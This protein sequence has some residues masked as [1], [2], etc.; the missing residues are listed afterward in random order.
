MN[1]SAWRIPNKVLS[2]VVSLMLAGF[3]G[4]SGLLT[5]YNGFFPALGGPNG[6]LY[7]LTLRLSQPW[8]PDIATVPAVFVAVDEASLSTPELAALPRALFQTAEPTFCPSGAV[9][10][11]SKAA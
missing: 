11:C 8:R 10:S 5:D 7:D 4:L 2:G 1:P 6:I 9:I 3:C